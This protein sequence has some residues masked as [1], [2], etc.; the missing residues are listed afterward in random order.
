MNDFRH[1]DVAYDSLSAAQLC[2]DGLV[3]SASH[4]ISRV[5]EKPEPERN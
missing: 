3:T 4:C 1:L 5:R 2:L